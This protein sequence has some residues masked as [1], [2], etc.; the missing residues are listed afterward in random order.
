MGSQIFRFQ[1]AD[2]SVS[3]G[4]EAAPSGQTLALGAPQQVGARLV[5]I[6]EGGK[7]AETFLLKLGRNVIGRDVGDIV[8]PDDGLLSG[9]HAS[10][11]FEKVSTGDYG[12]VVRDENSRNGVYLRLRTGWT[13]T[14]GDRFTAGR[15]VFLYDG[16]V[17]E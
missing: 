12:Y 13:L 6:V 14:K 4:R 1:H 7:E 8:L 16:D 17:V 5:R 2:T 3:D 11:A 9:T 15:Q 10:I